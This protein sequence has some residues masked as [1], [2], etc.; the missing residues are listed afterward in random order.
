MLIKI[1]DFFFK[2]IFFVVNNLKNI[3]NYQPIDKYYITKIKETFLI[4]DGNFF[5]LNHDDINALNTKLSSSSK[6]PFAEILKRI[7]EFY[8]F[9]DEINSDESIF[10][11]FE[12]KEKTYY[13]CKKVKNI[14]DK[15]F[16]GYSVKKLK[17]LN[18]NLISFVQYKDKDYTKL[19]QYYAGPLNNFY[20]DTEFTQYINEIYDIDSNS[21]IFENKLSSD[22]TDNNSDEDLLIS[23]LLLN[24]YKYSKPFDEII[25]LKNNISN[26]KI[27][28][29]NNFDSKLIKKNFTNFKFTIDKTY[30][31]NLLKDVF[32]SFNKKLK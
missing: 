3:I 18:N 12:V 22:N 17:C 16:E 19:F 20:S 27:E 6:L 23:D 28:F 29:S 26:E 4:K 8:K 13:L 5:N 7:Q 21:F 2:Q 30:F 24:D 32:N 11:K 10:I 1:F 15:N 14:V 31:C 9:E 25:K